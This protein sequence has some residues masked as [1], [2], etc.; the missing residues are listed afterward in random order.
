MG[1]AGADREG[2]GR[3]LRGC[4]GHLG[5]HFKGARKGLKNPLRAFRCK[6]A[7]GFGLRAFSLSLAV[8]CACRV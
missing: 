6:T 3:V 8:S 5:T 2:D 1:L 4:P 7:I